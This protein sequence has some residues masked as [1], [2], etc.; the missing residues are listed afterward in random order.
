[1]GRSSLPI[2]GRHRSV[3]REPPAA[4]IERAVDAQ[5]RPIT[6]KEREKRAF[7]PGVMAM[8]L[9]VVALGA[10]IGQAIRHWFPGNQAA[11]LTAA[12]T[13]GGR[14]GRYSTAIGDAQH[15]RIRVV[16]FARG[17]AG[18]TA[19]LSGGSTVP[20]AIEAMDSFAARP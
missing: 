11:A 4:V 5:P 7:K 19:I 20:S 15:N 2:G 10:G 6:R 17:G 14:V 16:P 1:G 8:L 9:L 18:F 12:E 13:P 3:T